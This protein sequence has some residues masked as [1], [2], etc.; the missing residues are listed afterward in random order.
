MHQQ[1]V[2]SNQ[3]SIPVDLLANKRKEMQLAIIKSLNRASLTGKSEVVT[4]IITA[5]CNKIYC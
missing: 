4:S 5:H 1:E 3:V 2:T